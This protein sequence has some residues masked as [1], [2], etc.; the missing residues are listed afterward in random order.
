MSGNPERGRHGGIKG[1]ELKLFIQDSE[2]EDVD[3]EYCSQYPDDA[4][5]SPAEPADLVEWRLLERTVQHAPGGTIDA[6]G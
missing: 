6:V 2:N 1:A 5:H 3:Q 4:R